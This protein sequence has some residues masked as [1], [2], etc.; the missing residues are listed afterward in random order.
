MWNKRPTQQAQR[1][2][3]P[4]FAYF[5]R[6]FFL[7]KSPCIGQKN[8]AHLTHARTHT[9][10]LEHT[11]NEGGTRVVGWFRA[12][13]IER[14]ILLYKCAG[15]GGRETLRIHTHFQW[16]G[17][18]H[19][20]H[21]WQKGGPVPRL[22]R[23][24]P[25]RESPLHVNVCDEQVLWWNAVIEGGPLIRGWFKRQ[26]KWRS[27]CCSFFVCLFRIE[28]GQWMLCYIQKLKQT[29]KNWK[30]KHWQ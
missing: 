24:S 7:R 5:M 30:I 10:A 2:S 27:L 26:A 1:P 4:P 12:R 20:Y 16:S 23:G 17:R 8:V 14:E 25:P 11:L 15:G 9:R 19:Y 28:S 22:P 13:C 29:K 18:L 6:H 21:K 3:L